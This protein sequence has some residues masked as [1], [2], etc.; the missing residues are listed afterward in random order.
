MLRKPHRYT[1]GG[2]IVDGDDASLI[3]QLKDRLQKALTFH[4]PGDHRACISQK[5][6]LSDVFYPQDETH[7]LWYDRV[8]EAC[9]TIVRENPQIIRLKFEDLTIMPDGR[10]VVLVQMLWRNPRNE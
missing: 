8:E 6:V 1:T 2:A 10:M 5:L 9:S 7:Y 3:V 4:P